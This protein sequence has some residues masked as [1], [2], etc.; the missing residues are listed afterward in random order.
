M[1]STNVANP[2]IPMKQDVALPHKTHQL[3]VAYKCIKGAFDITSS[4][5][6]GILLIIPCAFI[7]LIIFLI[8]PGNPFYMQ[9]RVG[10]YG[11][12]IKIIKFRTMVKNADCLETMLTPEQ[13]EQYI[14][15]FKLDDD[16][17][18]LPYNVGRFMRKLSI[19][20]IPQIIYN[21][22]FKRNMSVVGPRPILREELEMHYTPDEQNLLVSVKPGLTGFW[23]AYGRNDVHYGNGKRQKMELYYARHCS[24]SFDMKIIFHTIKAVLTQKGAK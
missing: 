10:Q 13:Y 24:L 17:R 12:P 5:L 18:L 15:E 21:V 2:E 4:F 8:D 20:E 14:K 9:E 6:C 3:H 1:K 19:D 22:F 23:Q 7:A 16:P 11:S